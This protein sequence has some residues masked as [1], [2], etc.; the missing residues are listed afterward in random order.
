MKLFDNFELLGE[1]VKALTCHFGMR[2]SIKVTGSSRREEQDSEQYKIRVYLFEAE[3]IGHSDFLLKMHISF[4][5]KPLVFE[6]IPGMPSSRHLLSLAPAPALL[7]QTSRSPS[8]GLLPWSPAHTICP[9]RL[10]PWWV[11]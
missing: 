1:R 10:S 3:I 5:C 7:T 9:Q 8:Y 2:L 6:L 11:S 4:F